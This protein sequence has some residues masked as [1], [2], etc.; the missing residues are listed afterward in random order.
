MS[1]GALGIGTVLDGRFR[2]DEVS[3]WGPPMVTCTGLRLSDRLPVTLKV[4][5]PVLATNREHHG[6]F[7][8]EAALLRRIHHPAVPELLEVMDGPSEHFIAIELCAGGETLEQRIARTGGLP[9]DEVLQHVRA[10]LDF[11]HFLDAQQVIH[12]DLAPKNLVYTFDGKREYLRVFGLGSAREAD[13]DSEKLTSFGTTL[14][15]PEYQSPEQINSGVVDARAD[16]YQLGCV[17]YA[18]L[19]GRPPFLAERP[20]ELMAMHLRQ[21]PTPPS[22]L[23]PGLELPPGLE[24]WI[25]CCL[26]KTPGERFANARKAID[27]L[28][29]A[30]RTGEVPHWTLSERPPV[31]ALGAPPA[32]RGR[33]AA[34]PQPG[35]PGAARRRAA[36]PASRGPLLWLGL[37]AVGALVAGAVLLLS[38]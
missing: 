20:H 32:G 1:S 11:L 23:R 22:R 18:M 34:A 33:Q 14:G 28:E 5:N 24:P 7:L 37:A 27:A 29:S 21:E 17:A 35:A 15:T 25:L 30:L 2:I 38:R 13:S 16:L 8:R 6:R 4:L 12:R 19:T 31:A 3:D 26:R 36:A 9:P 10:L